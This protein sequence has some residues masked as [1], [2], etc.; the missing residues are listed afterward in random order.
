MLLLLL[1][2]FVVLA[3]KVT[4]HHQINTD[5]IIAIALVIQVFRSV[6]GN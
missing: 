5:S 4:T 2:S 3:Q 1:V 6:V